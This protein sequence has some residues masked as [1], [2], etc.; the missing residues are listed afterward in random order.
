MGCTKEEFTYLS[1]DQ[2]T[3]IHAVC[4]RPEGEVRGIIQISHGM[5]EHIGRYEEFA[6]FLTKQGFAVV[7][8]DHLGHGK[9]VV[10]N[11]KWGYFAEKDG[12]RTLLRDMHSLHRRFAGLYPEKP[13]FLL[14]HSM[15]SFLARQYL[16]CY[17]EH[18]SGAV[19]SGTG[20]HSRWEVKLGMGICRSIARV[21]G[22][23]YRSSLVNQMA[24]GGFNRCITNPRTAHDWLTKDEAIVDAYRADPA[25]SFQF[26]LNGYYN[27]F[28]S[29]YKLTLP[30]Y[31]EK[32][33]ADLPM[34]FV[35]GKADPV[36]NF[37]KGVQKAVQSV[38]DAGV[39]NVECRLYEKDR[40][41]ILNETDREQVFADILEWLEKQMRQVEIG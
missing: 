23:E 12:N 35:A 40:H 11:E 37:G 9:S 29:L 31:L 34:L 1:Q 21:L 32:M 4:W 14:G 10:S 15:G 33:P 13:Y 39:K 41:E 26:T 3:R 17:G 24:F 19:I 28:Y 8:N 16:C 36:G 2:I 38:R 25:C 7:G 30:E 18:L 22:W 6:Q 5:V 20:W 27:L